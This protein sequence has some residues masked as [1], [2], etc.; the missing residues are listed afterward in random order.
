MCIRDRDNTG[1]YQ[2][3]RA[4]RCDY[5]AYGPCLTD[6]SYVEE[7]S[8]AE[9]ASRVQV[10]I[11]RSDDYVRAFHHLRYDVRQPVK[12]QRLAFYQLGADH[13]N[14]TPARGVAIGNLNGLVEEWQPIRAKDVYERRGVA[15]AGEQPWISIH[16][17]DR[18]AV[19]EGGA[20]A[21]RGLIVR[22][23]KAVLGGKPCR[24]PHASFFATEYGKGN[25]RTVVELSPP[26]DLPAL[27]RGDFVEAD[28]E[29]V[30]F[31]T[32]PRAYYGPNLTF[33]KVL[34][35]DADTW[36]LVQ[37]E[38]AGNAL[39]VSRRTGKVTRNYPL[40]LTADAKGR[41]ACDVA[42]GVGYVP[43]TFSGLKDYRGFE[44]L[45]DGHP[46]DQ[47]VHG[48][49]FWQTDYD[50]CQG[51]WRLTYNLLRDGQ[52]PSRLELRPTK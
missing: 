36:R 7:T 33:R 12:W 52:G 16:G 1:R 42:G 21:S 27:Q 46:L 18:A 4:T 25:F 29:L 49:D 22:S 17:I 38:A 51:R 13:Y 8:G 40:A 31:P 45:V 26:P 23:W 41:A 3:F 11:A 30:V 50:A 20:L 19:G 5:R 9:I 10:S 37:R 24:E 2:G 47:A 44:L 15:L 14:D 32:D 48:N 39:Q 28:I 6:V 34:E 35:A 43:V